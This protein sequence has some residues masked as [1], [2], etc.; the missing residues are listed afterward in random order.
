M[1]HMILLAK[2]LVITVLMNMM[3][4]S[5]SA[6]IGPQLQNAVKSTEGVK[7]LGPNPDLS[8]NKSLSG[9]ADED[10]SG[11]VTLGD[12]L[13]FT[14][15]ATNAGDVMLNQV[16]VNDDMI[17]PNQITC[18]TLAIGAVCGLVGTYQVQQS[19]VNNGELSNMASAGSDETGQQSDTIVLTV[20]VGTN[21][22]PSPTRVPSSSIFGQILLLLMLLGVVVFRQGQTSL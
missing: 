3:L 7:Q 21:P 16:T 15:E 22:M 2:L 6:A 14:I 1:K 4:L 20:S 9:N 5:E 17:T 19:D 12:T 11:S 8:I 10:G 18:N 13:E